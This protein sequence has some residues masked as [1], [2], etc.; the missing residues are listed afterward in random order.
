MVELNPTE[1]NNIE[2]IKIQLLTYNDCEEESARDG[3]SSG[4]T[5]A[6]P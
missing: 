4:L 1:V 3:P 2:D 6:A 5:P